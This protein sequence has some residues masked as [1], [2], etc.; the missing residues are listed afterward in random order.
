MSLFAALTEKEAEFCYPTD[1]TKPNVVSNKLKKLQLK[2]REKVQTSYTVS[3]K[4][5][6]VSNEQVG[7]DLTPK[8]PRVRSL[9]HRMVVEVSLA[10]NA[11]ECS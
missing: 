3:A 7:E 1:H 10:S 11:T 2:R 8:W 5:H 6:M 9:D 4:F